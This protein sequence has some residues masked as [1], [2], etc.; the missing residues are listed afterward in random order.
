MK[1]KLNILYMV[2]LLVIFQ[3]CYP[4]GP[5]YVD[6]LDIVY[7]NYDPD[8]N[9]QETLTFALPDSV[10]KIN[11]TDFQN[12]NG[13]AK[14]EFIS[15]QYATVILETI[16]DNMISYGWSEV[17]KTE[18][19]DVIILCSV[20]STTHIYYYYDWY[21]WNWW[22]PGWYSGWSWYYPYYYPTYRTGYR[23]GTLFIQMADAKNTVT[24][25]NIIIPWSAEVNGLLQGSTAS[26]NTRFKNTINQAFV[27]S[28]YLKHY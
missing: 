1:R 2:I 27:Q 12:Q 20:T 8:F 7:T 4:D 26:L 11:G 13:S 16:R 24:D 21:Y 6:D 28:A 22:Y 17:E 25:G 3:S 10:I 15:P 19:P 18:N 23:S 9:F 5:E 14:P